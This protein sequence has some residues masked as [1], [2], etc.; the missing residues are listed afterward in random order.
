MLCLYAAAGEGL[1]E[2]TGEP[3]IREES[4]EVDLSGDS[5]IAGNQGQA[6]EEKEKSPRTDQQTQE[7]EVHLIREFQLTIGLSIAA[8]QMERPFVFVFVLFCF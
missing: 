1:L 5:D 3:L 4:V 6:E 8:Q 2:F 7:L